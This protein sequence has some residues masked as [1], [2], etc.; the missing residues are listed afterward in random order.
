MYV[1]YLF[2]MASLFISSAIRHESCSSDMGGAQEVTAKLQ[3]KSTFSAVRAN[4]KLSS[5]GMREL[6]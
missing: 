3:N 2:I 1:L 4:S 6:S 5:I